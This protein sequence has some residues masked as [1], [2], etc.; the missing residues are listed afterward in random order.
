MG[1]LGTRGVQEMITHRLGGGVRDFVTAVNKP[2]LKTL[3]RRVGGLTSLMNDPWGEKVAGVV[4]T[5]S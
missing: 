2:Y 1:T 3:I 4:E 5:T